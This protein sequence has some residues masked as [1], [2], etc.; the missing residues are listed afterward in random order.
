MPLFRELHEEK[1]GT[2]VLAPRKTIVANFIEIASNSG[3][4]SFALKRVMDSGIKANISWRILIL[5]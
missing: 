1:S 3:Q 2:R 4:F 5:W